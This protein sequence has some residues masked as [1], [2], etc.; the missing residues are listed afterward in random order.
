[1]PPSPGAIKRMVVLMMENRSFD[2]ML[3]FAR[4][5][6]WKINGLDG[7]ES[8]SD[9]RDNIVR[10]TNDAVYSGDFPGTDDPGHSTF[11]VLTQLYGDPRT[12]IGSTPTM[13]GFVRSY[14]EKIHDP[15][16]AHRVMKCFS[17]KSLPVLTKLAQEFAVCDQWFS[18]LPGP[19]FPNRAFAHGATSI[20]RVD[21]GVDWLHMSKTIY[22]LFAENGLDSRIYYHDSTMAMTFR[23][24]MNQGRYFGDIEDFWSDCKKDRLPTYSFIEPRYA[25]S[26]DDNDEY[27]SASDQHPDHNV[28]EGEIL[29]GRVFNSIWKDPAVRNSTLLV[30]VYDEHGG[31]YDHVKPIP[32]VNPD[33]KVWA[34][35]AASLDPPF[36]FTRFGVRVPAVLISPYIERGTIDHNVYDHTSLIA[37]ARKLFL[38]D[39][40][41]KFLTQR[42][43]IANTFDQNLSRSDARE[44]N[45]N[46]SPTYLGAPLSDHLRAHVNLAALLEQRAIPQEL[47]TGVDPDALTTEG[48]ASEYLLKIKQNLLAIASP[49]DPGEGAAS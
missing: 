11:D 17:P 16:K 43:R 12:P 20:G 36:N 46:L 7:T 26:K 2:H 19:T 22:E 47:R 6:T 45:V 4:D 21:M 31:L 41:S 8:N 32:T 18:S 9:S 42:D 14:E 24:L 33:G 38:S 1:M 25:N 39:W 30:V 48:A 37:T 23:G 3:G 34:G 49:A 35:N 5:D 13:E 15:L 28:E 27:F 44:E 40:Q 10:V 29:I